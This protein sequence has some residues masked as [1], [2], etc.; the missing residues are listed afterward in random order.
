MEWVAT[1]FDRARISSNFIF[2]YSGGPVANSIS[3][4]G[5]PVKVLNWKDGRSCIGRLRLLKE[6]RRNGAEIA[7]F[8]DETPLTRWIGRIAGCAVTLFTQHGGSYITGIKSCPLAMLPVVRFDDQ[9][10]TLVLANS[11][12]TERA[13]NCF[14]RRSPSLTRMIHLGLDP[15]LTSSGATGGGSRLSPHPKRKQSCYVITFIGRLEVYKGAL[16]LAELA[17]ELNVRLGRS[18]E[19]RVVGDGSAR[20]NLQELAQRYRVADQLKILGSLDD[21]AEELDS[22]DVFV[23][24][25]LCNE[26]FGIAP[27]EAVARGIPVVAFDVGAVREILGEAPKSSIVAPGDVIGMAEA[28]LMWLRAERTH[29]KNS[30][31]DY[32]RTRFS[33][34]AYA[35]TLTRLYSELLSNKVRLTNTFP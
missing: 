22:A 28:I 4:L 19:I 35:E 6:L 8:H 24:P 16:V 23:F 2:L 5:Y 14:Y 13:H 32:V 33:V 30:G 7:H 9:C 10:T 3:K 34:S 12:W 20:I 31:L 25:S 17:R 27:L 18:F 15:R 29:W 11:K 21:V 1:A 26:S